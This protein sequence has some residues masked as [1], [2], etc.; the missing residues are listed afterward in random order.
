MLSMERAD[1][2]ALVGQLG[3][4]VEIDV[5]LTPMAMTANVLAAVAEPHGP[6]LSRVEIYRYDPKDP[7][8]VNVDRYIVVE[9]ATARWN[10]GAVVRVSSTEDNANLRAYLQHRVF[11]IKEESGQDHWLPALPGRISG[12]VRRP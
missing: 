6:G 9:D 12:V 2:Y 1:W 7:M 8:P 11:L 5:T 3:R 10:L 4:L